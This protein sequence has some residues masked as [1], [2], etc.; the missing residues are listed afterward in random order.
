MLG[1]DQLALQSIELGHQRL[2]MARAVEQDKAQ[3]ADQGAVFVAQR[4]TSDHEML[5]AEGHQIEHARLTAFHHL[6]QFARGEHLLDLLAEHAARVA[7]ANLLGVLVV[8]PD[9]P[10]LAINRNGA[11]TLR[12]QVVEQQGHSHRAK[13]LGGNADNQAVLVEVVAG[14]GHGRSSSRIRCGRLW[15]APSAGGNWRRTAEPA[16]PDGCTVV[17]IT[18]PGHGQ[19]LQKMSAPKCVRG[20]LRGAGY[21]PDQACHGA[22]SR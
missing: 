6:A 14:N 2:Q 5:A 11:L 21:D 13:T 4:N 17:S 7:D 16:R 22:C 9:N 18:T 19:R 12:V 20:T 3:C 8:N 10:R 1:R 15:V